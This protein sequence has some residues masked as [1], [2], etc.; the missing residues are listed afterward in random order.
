MIRILCLCLL[1]A[2]TYAQASEGESALEKAH[3]NLNNLPSLQR[4]AKL[5]VNYCLGCH[6]LQYQ[7][8]QRIADDLQ[9]D[10]KIVKENLLFTNGRIGDT[11]AIAMPKTDAEKW[12]GVAPPDLSLVARS[13]SVDWLYTYLKSFYKDDNRPYGVNNLLFKD[14]AM[15]HVLIG[16][17]GMQVKG[18]DH[19]LTLLEQG[20]LPPK[21]YDQ[22]IRDIVNFLAYVAEPVRTKREHLGAWVLAFLGVLFGLSYLLKKEYWKDVR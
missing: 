15:P 18:D 17:Q 10:P 22:A 1:L 14:V 13:R 12:F 19:T 20:S 16:L 4:G 9:I 7:R 6:A 21:E 5:Y 11:L 3:I 8:Y 2:M